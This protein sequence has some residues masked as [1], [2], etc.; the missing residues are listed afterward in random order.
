MSE[1]ILRC[2]FCNKSDD[3]VAKLVAGP[4][5]YICDS[6]VKIAIEIM[7]RSD[8]PLPLWKRMLG[9]IFGGQLRHAV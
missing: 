6:C 1:K 3:E 5:V 4:N 8:R 9:R 7:E 2:S